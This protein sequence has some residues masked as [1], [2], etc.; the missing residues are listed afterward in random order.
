MQ[1]ANL[2][3]GNTPALGMP[4]SYTNFVPEPLLD[5]L[6]E[7]EQNFTEAAQASLQHYKETGLHITLEEFSAWVEQIQ[8]DPTTPMPVCHV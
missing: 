3:L 8:Q 2:P 4:F 5:S 7:V 6:E 1:I